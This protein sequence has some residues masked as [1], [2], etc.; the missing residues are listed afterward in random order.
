MSSFVAVP[1][2][3]TEIFLELHVTDLEVIHEIGRQPEAEQM[4]YALGA[5]RLGVLSLKHARGELDLVSL[6]QESDRLMSDLQK[7]LASHA[8]ELRGGITSELAQYFDPHT[9]N[10][11]Q[12]IERLVK[13]GGELD[14]LLRKHLDGSDGTLAHTLALHV[15]T[16]SPLFRLLSPSEKAG[17]LAMLEKVVT[18]ALDAQ[19][20]SLAAN[21]T[22][23]DPQSA[24]SRLLRELTDANGGMKKEFKTDIDLLL[25]E[26]SLNDPDSALSRLVRQAEKTTMTISQ[27]FSLDDDASSFSRLSRA[28]DLR[29]TELSQT[30][31]EFQSDV[32]T[33]LAGLAASKRE[34]LASPLHGWDFEE[35]VGKVVLDFATQRGYTPDETSSFPGNLPRCKVGDFV[36]ALSSDSAA[37]TGRMV[38]EAKDAA[39]YS[40]KKA[41][42]ELAV[43]R[44]N[45]LAE[46]GVFVFS[47]SAAPANLEPIWRTGNDVIVVWDAVIDPTGSLLRAALAVAVSLLAGAEAGKNSRRPELERLG[48]A[49]ERIMR[50]TKDLA[51]VRK[52][53]DSA[54]TNAVKITETVERLQH[55]LEADCALL[56]GI[57]GGITEEEERPA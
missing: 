45:R 56:E 11:T 34:R 10:V 29:L 38:V 37:P 24:L 20:Q 12:R 54:R 25:K 30:Q 36:V 7:T 47:H 53:S 17:L 13:D 39:G 31:K 19:R 49:I 9:G 3:E 43:A 40:L 6:R 14:G 52:W 33:T 27:Q 15:G 28:L 8:T 44:K 32:R 2:E 46:V 4:T 55:S 5:L 48:Q 51:E 50:A 16:E 41:L 57:V 22:L 42:D 18:E 26:M 23:D 35:D 1:R 21:F